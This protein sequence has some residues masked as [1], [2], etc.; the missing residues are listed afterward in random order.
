M[1]N[2]VAYVTGWFVSLSWVAF[3]ASCCTIIGNT[4]KFCILI[5]YPD[6]PAID[7]QWFPTLLALASLIFAAL[8]NIYLAKKLPMI[9]GIMLAV[10][11]AT[12]VAI[13]V[14]LWTTSPRGNTQDVLFTFT[15]PGGW[16]N[17]GVASMV[18]LITSWG[19]LMGYDSSVHMSKSL[20]CTLQIAY[21]QY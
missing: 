1:R 2:F 14:T 9:E 16:P 19:S 8:F 3:L 10:H 21:L 18:G 5:Y 6:S 13:V 7:S 12:F 17:A 20:R 11:L 15:N 4:T